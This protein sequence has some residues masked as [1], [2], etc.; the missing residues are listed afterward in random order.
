MGQFE[1]GSIICRGEEGT[2]KRFQYCA[3][4]NY[5]QALLYF[6]AIQGHSG[7]TQ[8]DPSLQDLVVSPN[9]FVKY[10]FQIGN[11]HDL[12]SILRS[13]TVAG[14]KDAE[15]GKANSLLHR[16]EPYGDA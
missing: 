11:S 6:R 8:L 10:M 13:G 3:D 14:G 7:G 2:K 15:R 16:S 5:S 9:E 4:P 1:H 12:H